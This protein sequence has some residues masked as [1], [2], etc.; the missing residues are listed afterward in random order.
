MTF[1]DVATV[2]S[3]KPVCYAG[4]QLDGTSVVF[5]EEQLHA[6]VDNLQQLLTALTPKKEEPEPEKKFEF[7][8]EYGVVTI[9]AVPASAVLFIVVHGDADHA[10]HDDAD[11]AD[12]ADHDDAHIDAHSPAKTNNSYRKRISERLTKRSLLI[13]VI[14]QVS[15]VF[16]PGACLLNAV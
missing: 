15:R 8:Y 6:L 9:L 1:V 10:D 5:N 16:L 4:G 13:T 12:H 14:L 11:H 2:C 7:A 3:L